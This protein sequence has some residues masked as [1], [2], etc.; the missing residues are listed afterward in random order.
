[1]KALFQNYWNL[2]R[3]QPAVS[4]SIPHINSSCIWILEFTR[5]QEGISSSQVNFPEKK[6]ALP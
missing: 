6:Y 1:M 2:K 4:L 5:L 3:I